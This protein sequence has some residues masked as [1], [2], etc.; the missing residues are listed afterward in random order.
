MSEGEGGEGRSLKR[1]L[2]D[3][4]LFESLGCLFDGCATFAIPSVLIVL[5]LFVR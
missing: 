1:D 3:G 4:C 5:F 2:A